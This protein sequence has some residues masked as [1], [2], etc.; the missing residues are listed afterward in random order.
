MIAISIDVNESVIFVNSSDGVDNPT[1]S[2]AN[3]LTFNP[4][5]STFPGIKIELTITRPLRGPDELKTLGRGRGLQRGEEVV[6]I[7][8]GG[9][10]LLNESHR[11]ESLRV[12]L[13]YVKIVLIA[14]FDLNAIHTSRL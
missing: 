13:E 11:Q 5:I 14:I 2:L 7:D 4:A 9:L 8:P 6:E 3:E 12:N 10:L 1:A